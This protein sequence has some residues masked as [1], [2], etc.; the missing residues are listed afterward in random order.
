[1]GDEPREVLR[2]G[3]RDAWSAL[4]PLAALGV[5]ER[6]ERGAFE[7]HARQCPTCRREQRVYEH[8][9][10]WLPAAL[11]PVPPSP[12]LRGRVL[13]DACSAAGDGATRLLPPTRHD[14]ARLRWSAGLALAASVALAS[15]LSVALLQRDGAR[16]EAERARRAAAVA[17]GRAATLRAELARARQQAGHEHALRVALGR[18][19]ARVARL[20]GLPAAPA[21]ALA[22]VVWS[23]RGRDA[24]LLVTGL[25]S[26]PSGQVYEAWWLDAAG[27]PRRAGALHVDADGRGLLR[28]A[29][30]SERPRAAR[31]AVT[32]EPEGGRLLPSGPVLLLGSL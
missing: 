6:P 14:T 7:A 28:L 1:M 31:V 29:E 19:D 10:G 25:P 30:P 27:A 21:A 12:A 9:V 16:D 11:E 32:L 13:D 3:A 26:A 2:F 8:V 5:L 23:A 4:A 17:A 15:G 18:A 20:D 24:V 22:R